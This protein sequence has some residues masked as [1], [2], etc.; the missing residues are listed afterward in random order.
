MLLHLINHPPR[1]ASAALKTYSR[2][3]SE[4]PQKRKR[5]SEYNT[6]STTEFRQSLETFQDR[7]EGQGGYITHNLSISDQASVNIERS[8]E[9]QN[10]RS[11]PPVQGRNNESIEPKQRLTIQGSKHNSQSTSLV[12]TV[13][14]TFLL[15]THYFQIWLAKGIILIQYHYSE[16][17]T[18]SRH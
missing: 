4:L 8:N 7:T 17:L 16:D 1:S 3:R 13:S 18:S 6:P 5:Y 9:R 11:A 15:H 2:R 10:Q 14:I 12:Y